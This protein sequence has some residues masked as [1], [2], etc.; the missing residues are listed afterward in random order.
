MDT[1]R[2]PQFPV[3][4]VYVDIYKVVYLALILA[5]IA[6]LMIDVGLSYGLLQIYLIGIAIFGI[7]VVAWLGYR[8]GR[9]WALRLEQ[10]LSLGRML[11]VGFAS[12]IFLAGVVSLYSPIGWVLWYK[13]M[14]KVIDEMHRVWYWLGCAVLLILEIIYLR[15]LT[16][17]PR[18]EPRSALSEALS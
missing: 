9:S 3:R 10:V 18:N 14:F 2:S 11:M 6:L 13:L 12:T 5:N 15:A 16:R 7:N 17:A 8:G 4:T 1:K